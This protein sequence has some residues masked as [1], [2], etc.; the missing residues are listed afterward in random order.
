[1]RRHAFRLT[2]APTIACL[3]A[4]ALWLGGAGEGQGKD[5]RRVAPRWHPHVAE[6]RRYAKRRAGDVAFAVIDQRGRMRGVHMGRTA[7][8]ASVFKVMLMAAYLRRRGDRPLSA[9]GRDLLGPMIRRSDNVAATEVRDML[10]QARIERL[11]RAAGMRDFTYHPIWGMSRSSPRDQAR[12]MYRLSS[13]I[14]KRHPAMRAHLTARVFWRT[15]HAC[16]HALQPSVCKTSASR[17]KVGEKR[18]A[19]RCSR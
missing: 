3:A 12:F 11:A 14:P 19:A 4:A 7:P 16:G 9:R 1:M 17:W 10:G 2:L 6:A 8:M 18:A 13:Y 5:A 15:S